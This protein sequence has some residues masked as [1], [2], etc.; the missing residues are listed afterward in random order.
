MSSTGNSKLLNIVFMVAELGSICFGSKIS[1]R[2]AKVVLTWGKNI[3]PVRLNWETFA[4]ANMF[5]G[6]ARPMGG[7]QLPSILPLF[8]K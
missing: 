6:L 8:G 1:I 3:F 4:S 2:E 7:W 5:P